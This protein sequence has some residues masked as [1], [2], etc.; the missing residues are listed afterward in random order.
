MPAT[1]LRGTA[2]LP[3]SK[4][5]VNLQVEGVSVLENYAKKTIL[6][7][8]R[9]FTPIFHPY[10]KGLETLESRPVPRPVKHQALGSLEG[11]EGNHRRKGLRSRPPPPHPPS[12]E[13]SASTPLD[14]GPPRRSH[15]LVAGETTRSVRIWHR[16]TVKHRTLRAFR[17][18]RRSLRRPASTTSEPTHRQG[19]STLEEVLGSPIWELELTCFPIH[20]SPGLGPDRPRALV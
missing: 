18:I 4:W 10:K 17:P 20:V 8:L 6:P 15:I 1:R 7:P 12:T 14:P 13:E 5:P 2:T 16:L 19:Q 3:P 9:H 11:S